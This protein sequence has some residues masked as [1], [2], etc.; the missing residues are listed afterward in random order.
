MQ[1]SI[2]YSMKMWP[3]PVVQIWKSFSLNFSSFAVKTSTMCDSNSTINS[4]RVQWFKL[5]SPYVSP[6]KGAIFGFST[7]GPLHQYGTT[8]MD[9]SFDWALLLGCVVVFVCWWL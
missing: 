6:I 5:S 8:T 1:M 4:I 2:M 7:T 3:P 9:N